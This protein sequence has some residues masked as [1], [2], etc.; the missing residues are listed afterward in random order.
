MALNTAAR[1]GDMPALQ[2]A[3]ASGADLNARDNLRRTPLI[4]ASWAGQ[5]ESVHRGSPH[6]PT[7][8]CQAALKHPV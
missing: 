4:L 1:N 7:P 2:A 6:M 8:A 5:V 3:I